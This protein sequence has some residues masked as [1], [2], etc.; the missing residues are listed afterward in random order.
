V[1]TGV[2]ALGAGKRLWRVPHRLP[3][4]GQVQRRG[5]GCPAL[6]ALCNRISALDV[7]QTLTVEIK[8][9]VGAQSQ[10]V[11]VTEAPPQV[12]TSDAVLGRTI[13]PD[14]I[15]GLPLVNRNV[16]SELS[17]TPGVMAN[18]MSP[19]SNPSGTPV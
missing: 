6:N 17:L 11:T 18:N 9:V 15:V 10:T 1:D 5:D 13:E 16:Y 4:R 14:E 7:D 12:N 8:L 19:T 2:L 3:S